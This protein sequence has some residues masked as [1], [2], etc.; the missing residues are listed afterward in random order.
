[1]AWEKKVS[2]T[3]AVKAFLVS[4]GTAVNLEASVTR[5]RET[6][7]MHIAKQEAEEVLIKMCLDEVYDHYKGTFMNQNALWSATIKRMEAKV[8]TLGDPSLYS[9]LCKRIDAIIHEDS[10]ELGTGK[11]WVM[12]KGIGGGFGRAADHTPPASKP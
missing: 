5:F 9:F 3:E 7:V 1:M 12:R 4:E 11:T 8:P 10:G 6:A 2:M